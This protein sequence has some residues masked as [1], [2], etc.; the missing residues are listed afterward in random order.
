MDDPAKPP[1]PDTWP[2]PFHADSA[3]PLRAVLEDVLTACL[4]FA[5][6]EA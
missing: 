3:A 2:T 6:A 1:T 4:Q 5:R